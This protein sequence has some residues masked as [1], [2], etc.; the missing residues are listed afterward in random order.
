M[1]IA[2][3]CVFCYRELDEPGGLAFS[4]PTLSDIVG[5]HHI[6]RLCW[7]DRFWPFVEQT[8]RKLKPTETFTGLQPMDHILC[9]INGKEREGVVGHVEE[10][11]VGDDESEIG[12]FVWLGGT[13]ATIPASAII[14]VL[15]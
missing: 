5:K 1:A 11:P 9:L 3:K 15:S 2:M 13:F 14:R 7:D 12:Y 8:R 6:C 10:I 4:P